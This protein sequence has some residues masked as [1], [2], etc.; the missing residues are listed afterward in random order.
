MDAKQNPASTQGIAHYAIYFIIAIQQLLVFLFNLR[1]SFFSA[2]DIHAAELAHNANFLTNITTRID[3]HWA[4]LH[5][6]VNY[7]LQH[8]LPMNFPAAMLFLLGCHAMTLLM[9]HRLLQRLGVAR[10]SGWL[11]ALYAMNAYV[12][13]PMHWWAAG[14]HRFPYVLLA[15]TS[16]Y[17][18]VRFHQTGKISAALGALLATFLATG[19]FVK[20]ILIPLYWLAIFFCIVD[21]SRWREYRRDYALLA[22]GFFIAML[23]LVEYLLNTPFEYVHAPYNRDAFLLSLNLGIAA[24]AQIPLQ[25]PFLTTLSTPINCS[26]LLLI[27]LLCI[28]QPNAWRAAFAGAVVLLAN[29]A[30]IAASSRAK[31][32]GSWIMLV[33]RYYFELLFLLVIFGALILRPQSDRVRTNVSNDCRHQRITS[34]VKWPLFIR[35]TLQWLALQL[36]MLQRPQL[37]AASV[38]LLIVYGAAGWHTIIHSLEPSPK[39]NLWQGARFERNLL[40]DLAHFDAGPNTLA[41]TPIPDYFRYDPS[42]REQMMLSTYLALHHLR[43]PFRPANSASHRVDRQGNIVINA[44]NDTQN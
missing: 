39:N 42:G 11:L 36:S 34:L 31:L 37:G 7:I 21:F 22:T 28:R 38:F 16:C 4:P 32:Y 19:F 15:V 29:L 3:V 43:I 35:P 14:L 26:W 25:I 6:A 2:D 40:D 23:Y 44:I 27:T 8:S 5:R 17:G 1:T 20:G 33:P 30:M 41:D 9:L 10:A 24:A 18:F 12:P 13:I